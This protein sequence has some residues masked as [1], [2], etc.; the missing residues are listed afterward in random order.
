[1]IKILNFTILKL[2][3]LIIT[4]NFT[5]FQVNVNNGIPMDK[6]FGFTLTILFLVGLRIAV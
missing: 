2:S 6:Q 3:I 1:M 4:K 5:V